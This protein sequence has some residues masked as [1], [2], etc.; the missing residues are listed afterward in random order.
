M[1]VPLLVPIRRRNR[2]GS[3]GAGGGISLYRGHDNHKAVCC[4]DKQQ[5]RRECQRLQS[6]AFAS[7][8]QAHFRRHRDNL[9]LKT[10]KRSK[11]C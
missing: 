11:G 6:R 1:E 9:R 3:R 4:G 8:Q 7:P 2:A 10:S 5:S